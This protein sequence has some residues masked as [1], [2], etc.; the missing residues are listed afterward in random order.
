[1]PF[2]P[3]TIAIRGNGPLQPAEI[4]ARVYDHPGSDGDQ[5]YIASGTHIAL[6]GRRHADLNHERLRAHGNR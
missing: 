3:Q 4:A 1:M 6:A 5:Q 2:I